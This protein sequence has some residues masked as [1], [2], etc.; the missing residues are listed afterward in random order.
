MCFLIDFLKK[1]RY[2]TLYTD[3]FRVIQNKCSCL[4]RMLNGRI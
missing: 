1:G 2:Y 4:R 3:E